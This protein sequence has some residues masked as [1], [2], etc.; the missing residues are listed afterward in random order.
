MKPSAMFIAADVLENFQKNE[1]CLLPSAILQP[2][3]GSL[4]IKILSVFLSSTTVIFNKEK[5]L[6]FSCSRYETTKGG[7]LSFK[8]ICI[9]TERPDSGGI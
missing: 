9:V 6:N 7:V 4:S 2:Q 5:F 1:I 8:S 3:E